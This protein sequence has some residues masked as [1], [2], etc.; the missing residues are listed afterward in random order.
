MPTTLAVIKQQLDNHIGQ[1]I[2]ITTHIG[3][4]KMAVKSGVLKETFPAV[5][6]VELAALNNVERVS[7]SYTDVLTKNIIVEFN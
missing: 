2:K 5:F 7:Y 6:I 3:R 4:K 1:S